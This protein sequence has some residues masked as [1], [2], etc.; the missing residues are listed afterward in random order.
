M[1]VEKF[2][3]GSSRALGITG[4]VIGLGA[5]V[6]ILLEGISL[7]ALPWMVLCALVAAASWVALLRPQLRLTGE[8]LV[9]RNMVDQVTLPVA[10]VTDVEVRRFVLVRTGERRFTSAAVS[11]PLREV[12]RGAAVARPASYP[13]MVEGRIQACASAARAAGATPDLGDVRRSWA[14]PEIGVLAALTATLVLAV[15]L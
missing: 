13:D 1:Q 8:T 6:L 4:V 15:L 5:L 14:W 11:R 2:Q 3:S 10:A 9:L 12:A 7:D